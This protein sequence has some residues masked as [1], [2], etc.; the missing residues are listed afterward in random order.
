M[1]ACVIVDGPNFISRLIDI[2]ID[3]DL[4]TTKLSINALWNNLLKHTLR[5][6]FPNLLLTPGVEFYCSPKRP[7]STSDKLSEDQWISLQERIS[8]ENAVSVNKIE[9]RSRNEKGL[10]IAIATRMIELS[11]ICDIICLASSDKDFIP[12]IEY[13]K[14][15]GKYIVT[16]GIDIKHPPE[17]RNLSYLYIDAKSFLSKVGL[18]T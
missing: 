17:L 2:G 18:M 13:L 9:I 4:I 11:E 12:A 1:N 15:R 7:G 10:D 5:K 6:E 3:K 16:I 14:R 8:R